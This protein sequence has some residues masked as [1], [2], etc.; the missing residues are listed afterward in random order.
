MNLT[1]K[2]SQMTPKG[3]DLEATDLIEVSTLEAGS[4]VTKSIT[5]QELIDGI[6][7]AAVEWG[8][9]TGMLSSQTDLQTALNAKQATLISGTNIKSVFNQSLLGSGNVGYLHRTFTQGSNV[10]GTISEVQVFQLLIPANTFSA[11]DKLTF[12]AVFSR[13]VAVG[14][15][16]LRFKISTSSTM[17]SGSTGMIA[18]NNPASL[19]IYSKISRDM[20]ISGGNIRGANNNTPL[21]LDATSSTSAI[22]SQ[23]MDVTIDNYFYISVQP[24][25]ST[26][27]I[28]LEAVEIKN[29]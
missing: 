17:P 7:P 20:I 24:G 11:T 26:D 16:S 21:P 8:D 13:A 29:I 25:T 15:V 22:T 23:A 28:R 5:G 9:I 10:T 4:Y 3:S 19:Q 6:P 14:S 2:I 27:E 18:R 12:F 1:Q